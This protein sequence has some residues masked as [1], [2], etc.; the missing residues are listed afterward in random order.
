[1]GTSKSGLA[2]AAIAM[3]GLLAACAEPVPPQLANYGYYPGYERGIDQ[4][5]SATH[6]G[7]AATLDNVGPGGRTWRSVN[8]D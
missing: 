6:D 4:D 3:L 5:I 8:R 7:G 2:L 1:M